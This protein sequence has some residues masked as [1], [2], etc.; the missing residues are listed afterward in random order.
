MTI[1]IELQIA[2]YTKTLPHPIQFKN[3][4]LATL[5]DQNIVI[6]DLTI[7]IVDKQEMQLLNKQ[8]RAIDKPTNVLTF[9]YEPMPGIQSSTLGDI[10][11]CADVVEYEAAQCQKD[12]LA[13]WAH[14][15]I[16][17]CL[18]LLEFDHI[19]SADAD[20]METLEIKLLTTLG[21]N[22]PYAANK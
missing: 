3:W 19:D 9:P 7:R 5:H 11:I 18:H 2:S 6:A 8:F 13:H 4:A 12:Y 14:M 15:V 21:F 22:N 10:V 1:D 17:G 20:I 16:H